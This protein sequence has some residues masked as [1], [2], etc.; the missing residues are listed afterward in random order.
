MLRPYLRPW[1]VL[2]LLAAVL[3]GVV[4][5]PPPVEARSDILASWRAFYPQSKS[6]DVNCRLCHVNGGGG[7]PWNAYG[8]SIR[9]RI[10]DQGMTFDQAFAA[11]Q[12]LDAD[13]N[14]KTNLQEINANVQPGWKSGA[15]TAYASDGTT[16]TVTAPNIGR[17]DIALDNPITATIIS[18]GSLVI[19]LTTLVTDLIAPLD[20][21]S[22]PSLTND[23]FVVDQPG[24][25]WRVNLT[26]GAKQLFLDVSAQLVPL[27]ALGP[28]SFDE[29]GL[30]GFVFH[31]NYATN[32]LV[33]TFMTEP[34]TGTVDYTTLPV[35]ATAN[36]RSVIAQWTVDNP[37]AAQSVVNPASKK[38][39]LRIAKPQFNHN[40]G[41]LAFGPD[42]MLYIALGDG[43]GAD[44]TDGQPFIGGVPL[45]GHGSGGNGQDATNPLG[46]ILRINP[47]GTNAPNGN[48]GIPADNPFVAGGDTRLDEIFA[49]GLRNPFRLAFDRQT[50][51][52]YTGD[53]GQNKIEE[54]N[55][56]TSGGNYGWKYKEGTFFFDDNGTRSGFVTDIDPGNVPAGLIDPIAQYDHD[57]G[58]SIIGGFVYRGTKLAELN[59]VYIF[60]DWS[61]SFSTPQGRLFYLTPANTIREFRLPQARQL[62]IF[63]HGFGQDASGELYVLGNTTGIP[64]PTAEGKK[65]GVVLRMTAA[66]RS[67]YLPLIATAK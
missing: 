16:Q 24:Q 60:G 36:A 18:T 37:L 21:T 43:G 27:G 33:Y 40:G 65:T 64:F 63:L 8:W 62:E 9:Q 50:G 17:L 59:G 6:D 3:F 11:V 28:R 45:I 41:G 61:R 56:I 44:D 66:S 39:L 67:L 13:N 7:S 14:G 49:Y 10:V 15:N 34:V 2:F 52:L 31:P 4:S 26:T 47:L 1:L 23:L 57:D 55:I 54:V 12:A 53:V 19:S 20:A 48:Y 38:D 29:R 42:G 5:A 22:T 32:G 46:A 35:T 30:L 25:V 51:Q 58:I